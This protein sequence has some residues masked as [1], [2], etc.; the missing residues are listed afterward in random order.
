MSK[1]LTY[2]LQNEELKHVSNV[3]NG[4]SCNCICPHC[5]QTLIAKNNQ[6]NKKESHFS[7]YSAIECHVSK[8]I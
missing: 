4:L 3:E 7:H 8:L 6:K 5:K 2:G 1:I